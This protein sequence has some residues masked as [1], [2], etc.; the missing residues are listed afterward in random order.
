[1]RTLYD[2]QQE[3]VD[4][5]KEK[6]KTA[7]HPILVNA[8]VASGK[9]IMI[10]ETLLHAERQNMRALCFTMSSIL[11]K[12]NVQTFIEQGGNPG[13][14]CASMKQLD[15]NNKIIFA[16]PRSVLKSIYEKSELSNIQ[17]DLIIIDE[18]H[19]VNFVNDTLNKIFEKNSFFT[20]LLHY[21]IIKRHSG[22]VLKIVGFT[23]TSERMRQGEIVGPT[24]LFQEEIYT[25]TMQDMILKNRIVK[26]EFMETKATS[27]DFSNV[28]VNEKGVFNKTELQ[29][30][31]FNEKITAN[32][33]REIVELNCSGCFI[34][35]STIKHC[36]QAIKYL[37]AKQSAIITGSTKEELRDKIKQKA[38][39][40][41]IKYLIS[42]SILMEGVDIPRFDTVAW[43][44][45]TESRRI[46]IQGIGRAVR[47]FPGKTK[48]KIL[49]YAG[50][51]GRHGDIDAEIECKTIKENNQI[52]QNCPKCNAENKILA[53]KCKQ[54]DYFFIYKECP[55]CKTKNDICARKCINSQCKFQ[56][57]NENLPILQ[58][59]KYLN[60][61]HCDIKVVDLKI[62]YV[63]VTYKTDE[64][65]DVTEK[66][67]L[68]SK[69]SQFFFYYNFLKNVL[70]KDA[71]LYIRYLND[72]KVIKHIMQ[73]NK[74]AKPV[75]IVCMKNEYKTWIVLSRS[76]L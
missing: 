56:L 13:V 25:I 37:P 58:T 61:V 20:I 44:R 72:A 76:Y 42:V 30:V 39:D 36:K 9:S 54:C 48:A 32:I 2:Y 45:P 21:D 67:Y 60:V 12:Q 69:K 26:P 63:V 22:Q 16:S 23:G 24:K 74:N 5:V 17:F 40:G 47:L 31:V 66:F 3:C 41:I 14:Y 62:P 7:N 27:F 53:R 46:Y 43:L 59:Y 70:T 38:H 18:C 75:R 49:D 15:T 55:A 50:N 29:N 51:L 73:F 11:I 8:C 35:C 28:E 71:K 57:I 34:F 65:I 33:M 19:N 52:Y 10:A 64:K 1:M 4:I 68:T 6:L